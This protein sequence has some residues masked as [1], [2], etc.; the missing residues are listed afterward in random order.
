M[1]I[2]A[3][4]KPAANLSPSHKETVSV[5]NWGDWAGA[6][7]AVYEKKSEKNAT[8]GPRTERDVMVP[9]VGGFVGSERI[10]DLYGFV[11]HNTWRV[12]R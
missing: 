7:F 8:V 12:C 9:C 5:R 4:P 2:L 10:G 3:L 1:E 11:K 6:I